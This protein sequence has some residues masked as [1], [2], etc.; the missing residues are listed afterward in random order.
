MFGCVLGVFTPAPQRGGGA[1]GGEAGG[2]GE[3][4]GGLREAARLLHPHRRQDQV[5][6][7]DSRV[8]QGHPERQVPE[9]R[10]CFSFKAT[11]LRYYS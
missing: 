8:P 2:L 4:G 10:I 6:G 7:Q 11:M 1:P 3:A 5:R 9:S